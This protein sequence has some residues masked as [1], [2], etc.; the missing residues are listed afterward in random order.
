MSLKIA[1]FSNSTSEA[2]PERDLAVSIT[3]KVNKKEAT[4]TRYY[5]A[6]MAL[7]ALIGLIAAGFVSRFRFE[8]GEAPGSVEGRA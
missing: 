6:I 8:E 4:E 3:E 2:T 1:L 5:F 7:V